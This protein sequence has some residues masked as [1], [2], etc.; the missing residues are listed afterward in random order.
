MA[1]QLTDANKVKTPATVVLT[2]EDRHKV[3]PNGGY[4]T[5]QKTFD[6]EYL[7]PPPPIDKLIK[8]PLQRCVS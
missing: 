7:S 4:E 8:I 3:F 1:V 2:D 5:T 6:E